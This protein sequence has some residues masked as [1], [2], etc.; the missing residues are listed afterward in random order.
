[1][2]AVVI[3][4]QATADV[5]VIHR[6]TEGTQLAEVRLERHMVQPERRRNPVSVGLGGSTGSYGSGL[7]V[8]LGFDLSGRPPAM[9]E[10]MLG[11]VI[12]EKASGRVVWE[13]RAGF[14]VRADSPLATTQLGAAQLAA[15]LFRDFP[16][17]SGETV[18]VKLTP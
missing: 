3:H 9:T 13:G 14:S 7:G 16:G 2:G 4:A 18:L 6:Q 5:D 15:A 12:R 10:T 17:R 8:G 11:V 1:M